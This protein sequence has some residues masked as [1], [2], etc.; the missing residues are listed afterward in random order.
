V[1]A[2]E[3]VYQL[4]DKLRK[5][6]VVEDPSQP[7]ATGA[8]VSGTARIVED[9][10]E[11]VVVET[12]AGMPSYLVLSD[13]FDPGWS[14]SLDNRPAPIRPAYIAFRAVY[15]PEGSH[16]VVF[17]YR[18]AGFMMGL[19]LSGCGIVLGLVLW[20]RPRSL[21]GLAPEHTALGWPSWWRIGWFAAL[22]AIVLVSSVA[23][24]PGW[25]ISLHGRW[26]ES[27]HTHTWGAGMLAQKPYR[28]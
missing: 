1:Q 13:T 12:D 8:I 4:G 2:A 6:V 18:P 10:P 21:T 23:I 20:F 22:G 27:V 7:L 11:K 19:A 24:G 25:R 26:K 28:M 9:L 3:S 17:T 16:R 15:L 5:S 14:A